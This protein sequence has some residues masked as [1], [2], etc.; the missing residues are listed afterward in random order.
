MLN[1]WRELCGNLVLHVPNWTVPSRR[2]LYINTSRRDHPQNDQWRQF[3]KMDH[4]PVHR[5]HSSISKIALLPFDVLCIPR[6]RDRVDFMWQNMW[7]PGGTGRITNSL[8]VS[9]DN[10]LLLTRGCSFR[11]IA[12]SQLGFR[13]TSSNYCGIDFSPRSLPRWVICS[14]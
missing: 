4:S 12:A 9:S 10:S 3:R 11:N 6:D 13:P 1:P 14:N 7:W 5:L 8:R 2:M